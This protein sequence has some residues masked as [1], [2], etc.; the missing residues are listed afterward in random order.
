MGVAVDNAGNITVADWG[1]HRIQV[2]DTM[3]SFQRT[4]GHEGEGDGELK[5]PSGVA[6][7]ESGTVV[8]V[9]DGQN[10]RVQIF[11]GDGTFRRSIRRS[12]DSDEA[13]MV[14]CELNG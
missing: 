12:P 3:G 11:E 13:A 2:F 10:H 9:A 8:V 7:N 14:L 4:I 5:C 1:N 6:V